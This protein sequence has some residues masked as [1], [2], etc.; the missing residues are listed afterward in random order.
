MRGGNVAKT[1]FSHDDRQHLELQARYARSQMIANLLS[2]AI[3]ATVRFY[4]SN[5][6]ALRANFK[7]R[8]AE[9]QLFRMGD[10]ELADLGLCRADIPFA[11]REAAAEGVSPEFTTHTAPV[12]AANR[13]AGPNLF[14]A[15]RA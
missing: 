9:A 4:Q 12:V 10:R 3:L 11:V 2:D 1:G 5:T 7:L 6:A 8:A 13:N 14:W 15:G